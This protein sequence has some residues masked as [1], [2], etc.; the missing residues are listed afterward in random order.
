MRVRACTNVRTSRRYSRHSLLFSDKLTLHLQD[1]LL[2][3]IRNVLRYETGQRRQ[4]SCG[5]RDSHMPQTKGQ[6][7]ATSELG[8]DDMHDAW[9][10]SR[11]ARAPRLTASLASRAGGFFCWPRACSLSSSSSSSSQSPSARGRR[12]TPA[13]APKPHS[14]RAFCGG[15]DKPPP[16]MLHLD[17]SG[18]VSR[19]AGAEPMTGLPAPASRRLLQ[20]APHHLTTSP[21]LLAGRDHSRCIV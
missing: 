18:F 2:R 12:R 7:P 4:L 3:M 5:I 20:S 1:Q 15:A 6:R 14:C 8:G 9:S 19:S 11:V 10:P 21:L 16:Q 13:S 17:L